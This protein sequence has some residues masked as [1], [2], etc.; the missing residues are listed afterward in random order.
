MNSTAAPRTALPPPSPPVQ[1]PLSLLDRVARMV[2]KQGVGLGGL[3]A[4]EQALALAWVWAGL[5]AAEVWSEPELNALLKA[6]LAGPAEWLDT[7]HVEL[8]R[9]LVDAGWL[10]RDGYGRE[11]RRVVVPPTAHA[12]L[13]AGLAGV[14]TAV[15]AAARRQ[16]HATARAGRRQQ[17]L[18]AAAP[19][20]AAGQGGPA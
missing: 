19:E 17:W 12:A 3:P 14:D 5:P 18:Q 6:Q 11:Y 4:A 2:V 10:Q 20:P 7:D 16:D 13:A 8:R 1:S 15:W 9:W